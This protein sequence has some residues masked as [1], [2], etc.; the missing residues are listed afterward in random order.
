MQLRQFF[1]AIFWNCAGFVLVRIL[2]SGDRWY[3]MPA[4]I[5]LTVEMA[6][7]LGEN[8]Y[9]GV[10]PRWERWG[11]AAGVREVPCLWADLDG[12]D[13]SDGKQ[14][15]L[16]V[17]NRFEY[18]PSVVVDSG[19]GYHAYWL[20]REPE[21]VSSQGDRQRVKGYLRGLARAVGGDPAV[22]E[23]ARI[24]RVPGTRNLKDPDHPKLVRILQSNAERR[25]N[26]G[27][28]DSYWTEV[29]SKHV[30]VDLSG[31]AE[32]PQRF[33]TLLNQ[34][35]RLRATWNG[36]RPELRDH[37]R[38]GFDMSL[39]DYLVQAGRFT[40]GEIAAILRASPSGR[41]V[42][43]SDRYLSLT[44]GRARDWGRNFRTGREGGERGGLS[45]NSSIQVKEGDC[46]ENEGD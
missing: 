31:M 46:N 15:A 30:N 23:L 28:F 35:E 25:Y 6:K 13:F 44:I 1:D 42:E 4:K 26:L 32:I 7:A 3:V 17:L 10:C 37:T 14:E 20:L 43:A 34:N 2:P 38:S 33:Y 24:L 27:D 9:F 5:V 36:V 11:T 41:G 19:N 39:A 21:D 40:D 45:L 8:I 22:C 16:A 29:S 18:F 12:R